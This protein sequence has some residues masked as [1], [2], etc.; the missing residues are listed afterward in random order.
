MKIDEIRSLMEMMQKYQ[1][2]EVNLQD[3]SFQLSLKRASEVTPAAVPAA[4]PVQMIPA[5]SA[6]PVAPAPVPEEKPQITI[7]SPLVGSFYRAA[8]PDAKPFVQVGDKV[9]KDSVVCIIE[10]MKVMNEVKAEKSGIIREI[11]LNNGDAV[12][13]GQPMFVI[14]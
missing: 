2:S 9:N 11:L 6:A 14:E 1:V 8:S 12:E 5:V 3:Q 7:D 4:T 13:F 10:A